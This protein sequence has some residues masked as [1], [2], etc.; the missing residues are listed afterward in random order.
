MTSIRIECIEKSSESEKKSIQCTKTCTKTE[1]IPDA[2]PNVNYY[3][4]DLMSLIWFTT[5]L[6]NPFFLSNAHL[7]DYYS[8]CGIVLVIP[9]YPIISLFVQLVVFNLVFLLNELRLTTFSIASSSSTLH[10][11]S[12]IYYSSCKKNQIKLHLN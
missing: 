2:Y 12:L 3:K 4:W 5:K 6:V 9:F 8:T 10:T 1:C 11:W 7:Q